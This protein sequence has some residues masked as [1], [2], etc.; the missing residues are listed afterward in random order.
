MRVSA[1][2]LFGRMSA[3]A[4]KRAA[5]YAAVD[6]ELK[7][8]HR[9][10]GIGSGSTVVHVVDRIAQRVAEGSLK[11]D[12]VC[13]PSSWQ[14]TQLIRK[15]S[16]KLA[17]LDE[18]DRI[19]I[20]LDGADEADGKLNLIKGGGACQT[21]EKVVAH[22]SNR[23]VM[24]ADDSKESSQLGSKYPNVPVEVVPLA[25][26]ALCRELTEKHGA[27]SAVIRQATRKAGPVITDNSNFCLDVSFGP[28]ADPAELEQRL[29]QIPGVVTVG[30]FCG[31]ADVGYYGA[32]DGTSKRVE[33]N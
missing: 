8:S 21:Q 32:P 4:G 33:P 31:I 19:D 11:G 14:A 3:D 6:A 2:R 7:D 9:V 17:S 27:K 23:F 10:V 1:V 12:F 20:T 26:T 5:A 25:A 18:V 15:H 24:V 29:N 16:F 28:I 30:L 22:F 13:V